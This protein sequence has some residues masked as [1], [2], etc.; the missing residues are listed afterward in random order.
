MSHSMGMHS[1]PS[2]GDEVP[3]QK[4]TAVRKDVR[5]TLLICIGDLLPSWKICYLFEKRAGSHCV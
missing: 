5:H 2:S 1:S 3:V 4:E